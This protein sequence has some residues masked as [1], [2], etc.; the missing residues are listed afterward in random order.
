MASACTS[1]PARAAPARRRSPRRSRWRW[2]PDGR[3]TL[4]VE[5]EGRQGIAQLFDVPP[6]P[7]EERRVAV[8]PGGGE[9][10]ALAVD[11]E[12]ALLEYLEMFYKLRP[13]GPGAAQARRGR[14]RHHDRARPARRPAHRQDVRGGR[15]GGRRT[16]RRVYDAVVLDAPPTGRITRFLNV[17]AEVAGLA[18]VGPIAD[19]ADAVMSVLR[20]PQ[21]AV[22]LVTLLEEMPVQETRRRGR[23][24]ARTRA[25]GRRGHREHRTRRRRSA[26]DLTAAAQRPRST[27][28]RR[29]PTLRGSAASTDAGRSST[30]CSPRRREH[31]ERVALEQRERARAADARAGRRSSCRCSPRASTSAGCYELAE[32]AAQPGSS[33]IEQPSRR[34]R[35]ER[36]GERD[37]S[38]M[39]TSLD[40]DALLADPR[41]RIVVCCGSG[42]VGKTTTAAALALRAAERGRQVVVLT[43]DPARRL[44]QSMGLTE[45]DNIPA[46]VAGVGRRQRRRAARD[47]ARHEADVRRDRAR[48]TPTPDR[49]EQILQPLLPVA[50]VVASP[51]RRSTWRWRSSASC[52]RPGRVG[53]DRRRHPAVPVGAG[54]PR[55]AEAARVASSTAGSSA[56]CWRRPRPAAART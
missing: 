53:P 27:T 13:R 1:S 37:R 26:A 12:E 2:P 22:H 14:L 23:G 30:A 42:G 16:G 38:T 3:R 33:M 45:L 56:S 24:A 10:Y 55:R 29:V 34:A 28:R 6:L 4:L 19:Q 54:L 18:K 25:P 51:A 46:P 39:A 31:A 40:I 44:A 15:A 11:A 9:V 20:S 32:A 50:V 41:T 7:Y 47:D 17:N 43:I 52:A 49:A 5:V 35:N 36:D 21:T 8:A 48:R